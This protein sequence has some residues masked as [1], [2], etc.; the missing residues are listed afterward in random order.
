MGGG[1]RLVPG[2]QRQCLLWMIKT[3]GVDTRQRLIDGR[4]PRARDPDDPRAHLCTKRSISGREYCLSV[5]CGDK[6]RS[7]AV[8]F[9]LCDPR[10]PAR[11]QSEMTTDPSLNSKIQKD[12][13]RAVQ[14][15]AGNLLSRLIYPP[16]TT[17]RH[18]NS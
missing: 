10:P 18:H 3:A 11:R 9:F 14:T 7:D 16:I 2:N 4:R 6:R 15:L 1:G 5:R 12:G 17:H 13:C 8:L